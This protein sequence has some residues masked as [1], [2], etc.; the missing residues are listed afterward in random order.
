MMKVSKKD[1]SVATKFRDVAREKSQHKWSF[2]LQQTCLRLL[3]QRC[4]NDLAS[5]N[6][7]STLKEK[8][9]YRTCYSSVGLG[10]IS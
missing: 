4:A 1:A 6:F 10:K 9:D 2:S 5:W 3:T 7:S 8:S